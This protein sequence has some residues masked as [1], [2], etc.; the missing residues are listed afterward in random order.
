ME[1]PF[2]DNWRF[3]KAGGTPIS[4]TLPHDAMIYEKRQADC[5]N[6][7]NTG[8]FP[9]GVYYY[10]KNFSLSEKEVRG[11]VILH[12][13][14][15]YQN[16]TVFCN[17]SEAGRH[18]YGFTAF[19][20]DLSP[21]VNSG[22]N[23]LSVKVDNSLEPNCRW[24]SGSGIYRPVTLLLREKNYISSVHIRTVSIT[25]PKIQV[26]I[27]NTQPC[28]SHV[29]VYDGNTLLVQGNQGELILPDDV[30][31]W[32]AETPK[33]YTCLVKTAT[34][35]SRVSFGIR[36][37]KWNA[38]EGLLVNGISV[39]LR[40]GC[41]HHDHGVLGACEFKA[42]EE[43]RLR[44]LKGNGFNAVRISHHPA[45]Q[46]TLDLCD[47]LGIYVMN[48]TFDG[49]YTPKTYHD[50]SRCFEADW[51]SDIFAMVESSRNH[52]SMI[53]YSIGNEVSETAT[54]IGKD[55]CRKLC[56]YVHQLDSFR[57][58]TAGINVL[59]NVYAKMGFGVYKEKGEYIPE[60]LDC[61]KGYKEK[62]TGSAFFNAVTSKLGKLM[63][64]MS[65]GKRGARACEGADSLDILGLNYASSQYDYQTAHFPK[66]LLVGSETMVADLPYNWNR[67]M[68]YPQLIGDF[69][70]AAWDYLGEACI[71]D[72]TYHSYL[73][74]PLLAGQ[75][76]IDITGKPLASMAFMQ[77]VWGLRKEPFIAV[78]PLNHT[79]E[80]P[81]KG[82][83]QFTN[84][85]DSWEWKGWEGT[86]ATVEVYANAD[87]IRLLLNGKTVAQRRIKGY[88]T[89]F[90]IPYQLGVL[91]AQALDKDGSICSEFSLKS[92]ESETVLTVKPEQTVLKA[93]GQDLCY[94]P[95][96]F[97]DRNGVLKPYI[98]QPVEIQVDGAAVLAGF[99][100]AR[101][102]SEEYFNSNLCTAYR[103]RCLAVLR[104]TEKS[105]QV[106]VTVRADDV[107]T[108]TINI[109]VI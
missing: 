108:N 16:C 43:R 50:Y 70:W 76:M 18:R 59:L 46:I 105:G 56:E 40:G 8:Y 2:N 27:T 68:K 80:T 20:I 72:W 37:L 101:C 61:G 74:L 25:P 99:G 66:R 19:D 6:G 92:A 98:E 65:H 23:M 3:Y 26:E 34:D 36:S 79:Y 10:E 62:K 75:G 94:I 67:V 31:L 100:S 52:P 69:V 104:S 54:K 13:E 28:E 77:V 22:D 89:M 85:I 78:Q 86:P 41:I 96:E 35:E 32:S 51:Q 87:S 95:I 107:N 103:G 64:F 84:A 1:L 17:G 63:F 49:W 38:E 48:E 47:R 71:G 30:T 21:Y 39:K 7:V 81:E 73:G 55:A 44:I 58:V 9:G 91:T 11:S 4:V 15:V 106:T 57:P 60:P 83:W 33:L 14:G 45:S 24:Y 109:E 97:T 90:Q 42:A 29:F 88:K 93:D 82:A 12:F 102:K 5:P 53:M